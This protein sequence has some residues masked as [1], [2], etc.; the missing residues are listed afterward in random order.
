MAAQQPEIRQL[1]GQARRRPYG[2]GGGG[3]GPGLTLGDVLVLFVDVGRTGGVDGFSMAVGTRAFGG[4]QCRRRL[5][6][7][8][9]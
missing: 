7:S 4:P 8:R 1:R 3:D 9:R 2:S 5:C 6:Q